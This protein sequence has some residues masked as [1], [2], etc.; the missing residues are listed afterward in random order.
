MYEGMYEFLM[1]SLKIFLM[2]SQEALRK[3]FLEENR[4]GSLR[5]PW[6]SS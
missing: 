1:Q 4:E 3:K 6:V 2:E 5:K